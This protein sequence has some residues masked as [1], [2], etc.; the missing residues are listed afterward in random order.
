[1]FGSS[2]NMN[3]SVKSNQESSDFFAAAYENGPLKA[4]AIIT[5][6]LCVIFLASSGYGMIWYERYGSDKKRNLINR[7]FSS[8]CWTGIQFYVLVLPLEIGRHIFGPMPE[9]ICLFQ[10]IHKNMITTQ[11]VLFINGVS[12]S[13][14]LFVF[15]LKN[16]SD[17]KDEFWHSFLNKWVVFFGIISQIIFVSLPGIQPLNFYLC[18]GQNPKR[19]EGNSVV[20][21]NNV[22]S[23]LFLLSLVLQI[24]V[25]VRFVVHR[26]KIDT[27]SSN[28]LKENFRKEICSDILIF[29]LFSFFL[30]FYAYLVMT[31]N[32]MDP[33]QINISP[34]FL[35]IYALHFGYPMFACSIFSTLFYARNGHLRATL[36]EEILE[37]LGKQSS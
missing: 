25:A 9:F 19:N 27:A 13:R 1:M 23:I 36:W 31:V 3:E 11:C 10:L 30:C 35:Y 33:L 14:Y 29:V 21:R 8:V 12:I 4:F 2:T 37:I 17:F 28:S 15:Y 32:Q 26:I 24:A 6:V 34:N 5:T 18:T 7:L 16:P 20:K 22:V